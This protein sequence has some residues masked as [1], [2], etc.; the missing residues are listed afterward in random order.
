[1]TKSFCL[2]HK[3]QELLIGGNEKNKPNGTIYFYCPICDK[4]RS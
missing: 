4:I 3:K 1:M 2:I